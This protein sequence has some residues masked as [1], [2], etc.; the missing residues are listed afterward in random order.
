MDESG[1]ERESTESAPPKGPAFWAWPLILISV[2]AIVLAPRL[3]PMAVEVTENENDASGLVVLKIQARII[4]AASRFDPKQVG[5]ELEGL[6][7]MATNDVSGAALAALHVFV[8][9][10][11]K[12]VE[13]ANGILDRRLEAEAADAEFIE[14]VRKALSEGVSETERESLRDEMGNFADFVPAPGIPR[15]WPKREEIQSRSLITLIL[16]G[17]FILGAFLCGGIGLILLIVGIIK[18][19]NGTL[20]TAKVGDVATGPA[21]LE[22]FALFLILLVLAQVAGWKLPWPFQIGLMIAGLMAVLTWPLRRAGLSWEELCRTLGLH[23][24]RGVF[25]EIFAGLIGYLSILPVA[26]VGLVLTVILT[27]IGQAVRGEAVPTPT[28]PIM[29]MMDGGWAALAFVFFLASV[30]APVV[31]EITFRG[32]FF[33]ALR[34][35]WS[36]LASGL[37]TGFIFAAIHPQGIFAI[38]PLMAI[39]FGLAMIREWRGSLIASVTAHAVNN[40]V[41]LVFAFFLLS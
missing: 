21:L 23:R 34:S 13:N 28:H 29:G 27:A 17:S 14:R 20:V 4:I 9:P 25:R 31:E 8:D 2:A 35:R 33:G 26:G 37:V 24:G 12:G 6:E 15:S 40:S 1:P 38:P 18:K 36:F 19:R 30:L 39:G 41:L 11:G 7:S 5:Q 32:A 3:L 10:G 16:G 22:G